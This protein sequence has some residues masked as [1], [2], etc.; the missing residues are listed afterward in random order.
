I[1][2]GRDVTSAA[3]R[4]IRQTSLQWIIITLI[5]ALNVVAI[6]A[7]VTDLHP[8]AQRA[9]GREFLDG[10]PNR[11]RCSRKAAIAQRLSRPA[12]A[13]SHEQLSGHAVIEWSGLAL[14][15]SPPPC[16]ARSLRTRPLVHTN[17]F[18]MPIE[19]PLSCVDPCTAVP[20]LPMLHS[21]RFLGVQRHFDIQ[22][23]L[24]RDGG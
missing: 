12:L 14:Y 6:E 20:A 8:G 17:R 4:S 5:K 2:Q 9:D 18:L 15:T 3:S 21:T 22:P 11:L 19:F 24:V 13:L 7:F 23:S 10:E 1:S 16:S